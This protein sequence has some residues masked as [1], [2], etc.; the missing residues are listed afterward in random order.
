MRWPRTILYAHCVVAVMCV[1][2]VAYGIS[3]YDAMWK[4]R[5]DVER[6]LSHPGGWPAYYLLHLSCL[7]FPVAVLATIPR[8]IAVWRFLALAFVELTLGLV[9]Y[10]ALQ[11]VFPIRE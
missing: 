11:M 10:A 5:L 7:A 4:L 2:S 9:Q 8:R 1:A 3:R 6:L